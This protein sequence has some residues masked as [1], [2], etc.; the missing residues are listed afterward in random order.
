[1]KNHVKPFA[2]VIVL[3]SLAANSPPTRAQS[4]RAAQTSPRLV[5]GVER[6]DSQ[7]RLVIT[8]SSE[9]LPFQG[10]ASVS[11]DA[12]S[13]AAVRLPLILAPGETL[14]LPVPAAA[15]SNNQYALAV[16]DQAG[17]LVLYKIAPATKAESEIVSE[18]TSQLSPNGGIKVTARLPRSSVNREAEIQLPDEV[19]AS[20]LTFSI[21]SATPIEDARFTLSGEDFK[22]SQ[23]VTLQGRVEVDFKLPVTS[24]E[25]RFNYTL[26]AKTGGLL[27]RGEVDLDKLAAPDAV[28]VSEL[29]FDRTAYAPGEAARVTIALQGEAPKG[30][31]LE[32]TVQERAGESLFK[33]SRKGINTAGKSR[34]EFLFDLPSEAK[35]EITFAYKV[36][37]GQTGL[38]F[39]SGV[40]QIPFVDAPPARTR[41]VSPPP[42]N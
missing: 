1:M 19:E 16:Y 26:T 24:S 33:D 7:L 30:Y 11:P 27:A 21:E 3:L 35:G 28:T 14:R 12:S 23:P 18:P 13:S 25:R 37:G 34:H 9:T 32:V 39:D 8:N 41:S 5:A 2:L 15:S 22:Q 6:N 40:R 20:V 17:A 4:A 42:S 10:V 29:T 31:L 38:L 36:F